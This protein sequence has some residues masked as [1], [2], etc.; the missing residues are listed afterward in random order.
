MTRYYTDR[1]EAEARCAAVTVDLPGG[2]IITTRN[3]PNPLRTKNWI[4]VAP[5]PGGTGVHKV[6]VLAEYI[7]RDAGIIGDLWVNVNDI[8]SARLDIGDPN[9]PDRLDKFRGEYLNEPPF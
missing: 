5:G 9:L 4:R 3:N 7:T 8:T 2:S 1:I 6:V